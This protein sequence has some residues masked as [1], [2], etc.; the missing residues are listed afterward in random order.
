MKNFPT[1]A[2]VGM[3]LGVILGLLSVV[4]VFVIWH[5]LQAPFERFYFPQLIGSTLAQTPLGTVTSLFQA[6]RSTRTY[7]V[8][9][10]G[11]RPLTNG[12]PLDPTRRTSVRFV[13][14]TP[15]IFGAWLRN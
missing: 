13:Q 15:L 4:P 5:Q 11:N 2:P 3:L 12:A 7:F 1:R 14:T 10:E 8:L 9:I 6:R